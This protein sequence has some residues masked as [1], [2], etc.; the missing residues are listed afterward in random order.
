MDTMI[1]KESVL[2]VPQ[3][4]LNVAVPLLAL[5]V[6]LQLTPITMD[7]ASVLMDTSLLLPL[8]DIA[9]DALT[10]LLPVLAQLRLLLVS[11][12]SNL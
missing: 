9:R 7:P 10:I 5:N 1:T 2:H 3:D 8:S 4:V 11:L 6:L 12:T